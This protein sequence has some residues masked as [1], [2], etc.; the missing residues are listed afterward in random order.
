MLISNTDSYKQT[1][2]IQI[3]QLLKESDHDA[4]K[5]QPLFNEWCIEFD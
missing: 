1:V 2:Q 4:P 5:N 3:R